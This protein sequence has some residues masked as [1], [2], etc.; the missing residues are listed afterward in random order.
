MPVSLKPILLSR[1]R[2]LKTFRQWVKF[3]NLPI[4]EDSFGSRGID[5]A[6]VAERGRVEHE[7]SFASLVRRLDLLFKTFR[8]EIDGAE[9][10]V[11]S[12]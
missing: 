6:Y 10:S 1:W 8:G 9:F 4:P 12:D 11:V 7:D 5:V 2:V 3:K